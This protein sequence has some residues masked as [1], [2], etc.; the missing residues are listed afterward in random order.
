MELYNKMLGMQRRRQKGKKYY[1][2]ESDSSDYYEE[3]AENDVYVKKK[4]IL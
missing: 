4:K 1:N 3:N 2:Y